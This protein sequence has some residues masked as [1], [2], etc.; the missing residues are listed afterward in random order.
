MADPLD[1]SKPDEAILAETEAKISGHPTFKS[2]DIW[3]SET[4][5]KMGISG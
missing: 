1:L 3:E 5:A 4:A 2:R